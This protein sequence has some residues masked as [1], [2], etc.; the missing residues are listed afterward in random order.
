MEGNRNQRLAKAAPV[1]SSLQNRDNRLPELIAHLTF[2]LPHLR[3]ER[4]AT[5]TAAQRSSRHRIRSND[6]CLDLQV[7]MHL[8]NTLA[9]R[10]AVFS[11]LVIGAPAVQ[12]RVESW[13]AQ[14]CMRGP[15]TN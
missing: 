14:R 2:R 6:N 3:A 1:P 4:A 5:V 10:R 11:P 8:Q 9:R 12:Y 15:W 7:V 13:R